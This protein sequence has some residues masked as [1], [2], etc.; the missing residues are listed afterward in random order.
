M[1]CCPLLSL[2]HPPASADSL[3]EEAPSWAGSTGGDAVYR[4]Q[5]WKHT[6][7]AGFQPPRPCIWAR[8][9]LKAA[10][11]LGTLVSEAFR[12]GVM[13]STNAC[14]YPCLIKKKT[15]PPKNPEIIANS[16]SLVFFLESLVEIKKLTNQG[17]RE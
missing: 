11:P 15:H 4:S 10:L 17:L 6:L 5:E 12:E 1:P 14:H 16:P 7:D 2:S 13:L 8:V 9:V 3:R